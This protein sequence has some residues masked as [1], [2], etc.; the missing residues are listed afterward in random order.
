MSLNPVADA[1]VQMEGAY[2]PNSINMAM[3]AQSGLWDV[4]HLVYAGQAG[5]QPVTINGRAWA[6]WPTPEAAYDGVLRD[7]MAKAR[8]GHTVESAIGKY[9]PPSENNTQQYIAFIESQ[10][11]VP[12]T[13]PLASLV[14]GT[15]FRSAGNVTPELEPAPAPAPAPSIDMFGTDPSDTQLVIMIAAAAAAGGLLLSAL[16]RHA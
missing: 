11:G 2:N 13:T 15:V 3:V 8:V 7:L 1:I 12:R 6:G 10:T 16:A 4:G 14:E 5:A 9:A